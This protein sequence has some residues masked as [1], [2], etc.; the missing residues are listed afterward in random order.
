MPTTSPRIS[1]VTTRLPGARVGAAYRAVIRFSGPV[2]EARVDWRLPQGLKW[3]V[4]GE[5]IVIRG[6]V[7]RATVSRFA[8]VLSSDDGPS[9]RHRF[10]LVVR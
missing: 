10:R 8:T 9:V 4:V 7:R 3:R 5:T 1:F 6:T 2:S